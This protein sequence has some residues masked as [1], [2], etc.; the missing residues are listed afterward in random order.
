MIILFS[1]SQFFNMID[2]CILNCYCTSGINPIWSQWMIFLLFFTNNA[3]VNIIGVYSY[4]AGL[5]RPHLVSWEQPIL[6][7][8]WSSEFQSRGG[9]TYETPEHWVT[10]YLSCICSLGFP[11]LVAE[12]FWNVPWDGEYQDGAHH[13][14]ADA[15]LGWDRSWTQDNRLYFTNWIE[16]MTNFSK[17]IPKIVIFFGITNFSISL[18]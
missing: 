3:C 5:F 11:L 10:S 16:F 13:E 6:W 17:N 14:V 8:R 12:M 9:A 15:G 4:V 2:L 7:R 18:S 1:N